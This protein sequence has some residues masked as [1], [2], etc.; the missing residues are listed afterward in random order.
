[1]KKVTDNEILLDVLKMMGEASIAKK[2]DEQIFKSKMR[3]SKTTIR[4]QLTEYI[5][6]EKET[7]FTDQLILECT[8]RGVYRFDRYRTLDVL[9]RNGLSYIRGREERER[10]KRKYKYI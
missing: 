10:L 1:M 3:G 8:Q 2:I 6:K 9:K 4:T 5:D 7:A